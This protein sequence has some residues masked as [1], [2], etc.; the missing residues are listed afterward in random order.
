MR[1][2]APLL[3]L[4]VAIVAGV[5]AIGGSAAAHECTDDPQTPQNPDECHETPV[6]PNWRGTYVPLFDLE[7]REDEAQRYD[8]QRW[9]DECN[10]GDPNSST[11]QSRQQCA[12][13]YGG[14]SGFPN[15]EDD[16]RAPN[17]LHVGFAATHCFLFEFAHQCEDHDASY[18][19][20]VHDAHGGA[21]YVDVCLSPNPESKYCDDGMMDTQVGV[22]IMDHNPC[23]T[24]VPIVACT[25]EYK[26][27]RPLDQEY[28]QA[29]MD[30]SAEQTQEILA[31][32][33][34]WLCGYGQYGGDECVV[35]QP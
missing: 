23:G 4:A 6:M 25:D 5:L 17:E 19:E 34:T 2:R 3:M 10:S 24:V 28:T 16:V 7:D 21:T 35:P 22:T 31:D 32:P 20:G 26:V 27:I 1:F 11:Y 12:W 33:Y 13:M 8:A 29:Q 18:G 30:N 15:R 9:R 14:T